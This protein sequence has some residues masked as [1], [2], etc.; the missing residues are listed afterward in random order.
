[1]KDST[2]E[3]PNSRIEDGQGHDECLEC[4]APGGVNCDPACPLVYLKREW[5]SLGTF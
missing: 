1:M 5:D 4:G 3:E 2:I